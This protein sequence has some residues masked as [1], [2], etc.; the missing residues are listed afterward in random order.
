MRFLAIDLGDVRSGLAV[1]DDVT[2]LVG[3]AGRVEVPIVREKGEALIEALAKAVDEHLG[4]RD[5]VVMGLPIN[6]DESE[7]PRARLVRAFADRLSVRI[8]RAIILQ[9]E[10]LTSVQ[11]DWT[12][13]GSGLT[14]KQ[15]KRRRDALAACAFLGDFLAARARQANLGHDDTGQSIE[16][17]GGFFPDDPSKD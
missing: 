2:G 16:D 7:G 13:G 5:G 15:K 3:P 8:G 11:A 6:M 14:N 10:R 1:G 12:M 9:D 4:L 17:P